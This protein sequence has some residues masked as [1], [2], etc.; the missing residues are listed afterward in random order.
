MIK[1]ML[2]STAELS[3]IQCIEGL[4]LGSYLSFL[5]GLLSFGLFL[6]FS[7][8]SCDILESEF[9]ICFCL[10]YGAH[11]YSLC[12]HWDLFASLSV[13]YGSA[14]SW[15]R[16]PLTVHQ[17]IWLTVLLHSPHLRD[18][19]QFLRGNVKHSNFLSAVASS[20]F[21]CLSAISNGSSQQI[22]CLL[23]QDVKSQP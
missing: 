9:F 22:S 11:Q 17:I 10:G 12:C 4:V 18:Q 7:A 8:C 13:V 5:G 2:W 23:Q 16:L 21:F 1:Y 19:W 3:F 15:L 20:P 6:F 14:Q